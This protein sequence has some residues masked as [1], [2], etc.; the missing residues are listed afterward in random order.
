MSLNAN[1]LKVLKACADNAMDAAGGDFGFTDEI[2][3]YVKE[4]LSVNQVKGYLSD[5]LNKGL[6]MIDHGEINDGEKY[7][8]I[9]FEK[10]TLEVL[11]NEG[12]MTAIEA[13]DFDCWHR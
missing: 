11:I 6:I 7:S 10:D 12:M 13:N 4:D 5:L 9:T 2:H 1:E 8:Q 3:A